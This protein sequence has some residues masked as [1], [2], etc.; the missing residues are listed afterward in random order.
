MSAE[1]AVCAW[2]SCECV[3]GKPP[4]PDLYREA[5]AAESRALERVGELETANEE[6]R[7]Q[8]AELTAAPAYTSPAPSRQVALFMRFD[9]IDGEYLIGHYTGTAALDEAKARA[10]EMWADAVF[11]IE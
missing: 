3:T 8:I 10:L 11:F 6:L 2:P 1:C 9:G 7:A 4:L 5:Y